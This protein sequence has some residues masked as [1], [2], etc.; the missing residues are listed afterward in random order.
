M[1]RLLGA[2]TCAVRRRVGAPLILTAILVLVPVGQANAQYDPSN[3]MDRLLKAIICLPQ[4]TREQIEQQKRETIN[5]D[6]SLEMKALKLEILDSCP[7][8]D[9]SDSNIRSSGRA[10]ALNAP[11]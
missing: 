11:K 10:K 9:E 3:P 6:D 5:S 2:A 4:L 1:K 8:S 7:A